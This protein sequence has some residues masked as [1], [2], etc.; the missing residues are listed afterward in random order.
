MRQFTSLVSSS[1][2]LVRSGLF[3][4]A[5]RN[6]HSRNNFRFST[7]CQ[8]EITRRLEPVS[9][10]FSEH[11]A[12]NHPLFTYLSEQSKEGFTPK[13]F[14]TYRDNFFRRTQ[15]TIPSIAST[16]R[17]A[18]IYGDF[19]A[20]ASAFKNLND[21]MGGGDVKNIHSQLLLENHNIHGMRVFGVD[22]LDRITDVENSKL[23][24]PEVEEYRRAKEQIFNM[25][26]PCIAGN[27]WAHELAADSML[28]NFRESL[29]DPYLDHYTK[30]EADHVMKFFT[31]HRDDSIIGG[32]V[33][34]KHEEMARESVE[35]AC[36]EGLS[37]IEQ[38]REGGL[39]F[40]DHQEK[41]WDGLLREIEKARL[42][43]NVVEPKAEKERDNRSA[44]SEIPSPR[45]QKVTLGKLHSEGVEGG[46]R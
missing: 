32:N 40:L 19:D 22:P 24:L 18:M 29:F 20:A 6:Y 45:V 2:A 5:A 25:P 42:V 43:G 28:D 31:A 3:S 8:K 9:Q 38:V 33:E 17:A 44:D 30:E 10:E 7:N 37:H 11:K 14:L 16:I 46:S 36:L 34:E 39:I 41:L 4:I 1:E 21:E 27:T 23:L 15:L 35:S 26:Y 13:Q 12:L